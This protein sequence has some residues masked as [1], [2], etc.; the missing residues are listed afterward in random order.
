MVFGL[1][2]SMLLVNM[3]IASAESEG[4]TVNIYKDMLTE[5][6]LATYFNTD[7]GNPVYSF[8]GNENKS[9][10]GFTSGSLSSKN[11]IT[12]KNFTISA[13]VLAVSS[14]AAITVSLGNVQGISK[15]TDVT[16]RWADSKIDIKSDNPDFLKQVPYASWATWTV[17][18][19]SYDYT[20]WFET[21]KWYDITLVAKDTKLYVFINGKYITSV[22]NKDGYDGSC[23]LKNSSQESVKLKNFNTY[24][25]AMLVAEPS[26]GKYSFLDAPACFLPGCSQ[27]FT[28]IPPTGE[29]PDTVNVTVSD[30]KNKYENIKVQPMNGKFTFSF[31]PRGIAGYQTIT[32][33]DSSSNVS[34][35]NLYL[36]AETVIDTKDEGFNNLFN[37]SATQIKNYWE[38]KVREFQNIKFKCTVPWIRDNTYIL[39]ASRYW[40]SA[41][42]MKAWVNFFLKNQTEEGFYLEKI[43]KMPA[44]GT[45]SY[46]D[47][48]CYKPLEDG[49]SV[50]ERLELEADVEYLMVQ[51]VYQVWMST[52][53]DEWM[54]STLEKLDKGLMYIRNTNTRW[55]NNLGLAIRVNTADTWDFA[56]GTKTGASRRINPWSNADPRYDATPMSMFYGDNTG[57]YQACWMIADMYKKAGNNEK[58]DYWKNA[59]ESV[60]KNVI[61]LAWNGDFFAHMVHIDPTVDNCPAQWKEDFEGDWT[62]LSLSNAY[63]LNRGML[64]EEYAS[65]IIESF[66]RMRDNLPKQEVV[67]GYLEDAIANEWISIYPSYRGGYYRGVPGRTNNGLLGSFTAGELAKGSFTYG[68]PEYGFDIISRMKE[69]CARDGEIF[70]MYGQNGQPSIYVGDNGGVGPGCWGSAAVYSA[71]VEGLAGFKDEGK[72]FKN[73][74]LT[75]AWAATNYDSVYSSVSYGASDNYI[76]YTAEHDKTNKK[77]K[78]TIVGDC[79]KL[80]MNL[81]VPKGNVPDK[82]TINGQDA[83]FDV[84]VLSGSNYATL[85]FDRNDNL[86]IDTVE[87]F[88]SEGVSNTELK[89]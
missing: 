29:T 51:A 4:G 44:S 33:R 56:Y 58:V 68:Y 55:D 62:R 41:D 84:K 74:E 72:Q 87:V 82:V 89:Y 75:P 48:D 11:A 36:N 83:D 20:D 17:F 80:S 86:E 15:A 35:F 40:E 14:G 7:E 50:L 63:T 8:E 57:Y 60:K 30:K 76:A 2:M 10:L 18:S 81:L 9:T 85:T 70:F 77:L 39:E 88:Y 71:I 65:K 69:L 24:E 52:G 1:I 79:T 67:G 13:S 16:F 3:P 26:N 27:E 28:Y 19:L 59:G 42:L 53:D 46:I 78:Y 32:I 61:D 64:N 34:E 47:P 23:I 22:Y 5:H 66:M 73:A 12:S 25:T 45:I 38:T 31:I 37:T 43:G 54:L 49:K 21:N 6:N